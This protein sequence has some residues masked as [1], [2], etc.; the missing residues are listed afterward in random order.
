[1]SLFYGAVLCFLNQHWKLGSALY[2]LSVSVKMNTIL[3]APGLL[4]VYL[5]NLNFGHVVLNLAIC[6]FV[7]GWFWYF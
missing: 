3:A 1:M 7:Q 2:S 5:R 6:A 4:V